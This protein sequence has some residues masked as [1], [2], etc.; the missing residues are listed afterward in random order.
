MEYQTNRDG[1]VLVGTY[2]AAVVW[3]VGIGVGWWVGSGIERHGAS[4]FIGGVGT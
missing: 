4:E 2:V 3:G 1:W